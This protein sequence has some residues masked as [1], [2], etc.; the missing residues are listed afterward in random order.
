MIKKNQ[1]RLLLML[2]VVF[3]LMIPDSGALAQGKR[4]VIQLSGIVLSEEDTTRGL[5][6]V[7][8]YVPKAGRGT[9]T[10]NLGYFSMPVLPGDEIVISAIGY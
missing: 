6:G 2:A 3:M 7:H 10:N 4:H 5:P 1:I 9:T 8:V